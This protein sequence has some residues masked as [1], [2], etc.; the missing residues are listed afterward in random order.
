MG[1]EFQILILITVAF[2]SVGI[3]YFVGKKNRKG[4]PVKEV[5]P[6]YY[7]AWGGHRRYNFFKGKE[8]RFLLLQ[9]I[10]DKNSAPVYLHTEKYLIIN[11]HK[12]SGQR[13]VVTE[14][15]KIRLMEDKD[16][17]NS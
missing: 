3:A 4:M 14:D 8:T 1:V 13:V 16:F 11:Q 2:F 12:F 7:T 15:Y 10:S 6:G 17:F 5:A 9:K